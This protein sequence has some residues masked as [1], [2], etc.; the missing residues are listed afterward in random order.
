MSRVP[1]DAHSAAAVPWCS[2]ALGIAASL[3]QCCLP[4]HTALRGTLLSESKTCSRQR[5][6]LRFVFL[7]LQTP[8]QNSSVFLLCLPP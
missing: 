8:L 1:G 6:E 5:D 2:A 3:L 7:S 4:A